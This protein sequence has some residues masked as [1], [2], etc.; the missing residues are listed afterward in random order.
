MTLKATQPYVKKKKS[1][2]SLWT[3]KVNWKFNGH[4]GTKKPNNVTRCLHKSPEK[5]R[6][7]SETKRFQRRMMSDISLTFPSS[8]QCGAVSRQHQK[9]LWICLHVTHALRDA[10]SFRGRPQ[11]WGLVM[12]SMDPG[13]LNGNHWSTDNGWLKALS[14]PLLDFNIREALEL[15]FL[16]GAVCQTKESWAWNMGSN[17]GTRP[18]RLAQ[19]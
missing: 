15:G 6:A 8:I 12:R 19:G 9:Y 5:P 14:T 17:S 1:N 3:K 11:L 10:G 4:L 16:S 13:R 18:W 7:T 2:P